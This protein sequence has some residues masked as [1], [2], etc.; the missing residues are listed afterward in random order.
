M[1]V[2]KFRGFLKPWEVEEDAV[3]WIL[4]RAVLPGDVGP[5]LDPL[6]GNGTLSPDLRD[7][8]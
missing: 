3:V 7:R 1:P 8:L 5:D 2:N 4:S 6:W